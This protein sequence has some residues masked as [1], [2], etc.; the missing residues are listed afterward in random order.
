MDDP[1]SFRLVTD[2]TGNSEVQRKY[3]VIIHHDES[4]FHANDDQVRM[5]VNQTPTRFVRSQGERL[6]RQV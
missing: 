6:Y 5:W 2:E 1:L 4:I 3:L